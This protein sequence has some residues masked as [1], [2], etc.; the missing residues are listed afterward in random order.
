MKQPRKNYRP[1]EKVVILNKDLLD[2]VTVCDLYAEYG[3][4]LTMFYRWQK[5]FL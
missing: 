4:P 1:Q 2:S 3:G 5:T